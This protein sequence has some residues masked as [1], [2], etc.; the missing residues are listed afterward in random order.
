MFWL[1]KNRKIYNFNELEVAQ[2][3]ENFR[4]ES[5]LYFSPSFDTISATGKNGAIIH[6][7]PKNIKPKKLKKGDLYLCDSG[8]QYFGG[9]T[10]ITRTF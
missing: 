6:Y 9:T 8:G 1:E 10:D 3:L 2:K 7:N 4:K 5:D